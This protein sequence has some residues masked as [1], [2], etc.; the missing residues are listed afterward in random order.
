M[1]GCVYTTSHWLPRP[2]KGNNTG[3]DQRLGKHDLGF[4]AK[5]VLRDTAQPATFLAPAVGPVE[6]CPAVNS[7]FT[8]AAGDVS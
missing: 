5:L 3:S 8:T 7:D 4:K 1:H 6:A 2:P